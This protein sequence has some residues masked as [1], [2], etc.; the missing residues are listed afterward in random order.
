MKKIVLNG[1]WNGKGINPLTKETIEFKEASV[2]GSNLNDIINS[3]CK[4]EDIFYRDNLEKYQ[5]YENFNYVYTKKFDVKKTDG[6]I[7]LVFERLDTYCDVYLNGTHLSYCDNG[8]I[9][10]RFDV[11]DMIREQ[12]NE[13]KIYFYSPIA[14]TEGKPMLKG[15]F[16]TE[17]MYTRRMQCTYGWDWVGRFVT[18]GI[19]SDVF[20]ELYQKNEPALEGIYV[21][22]KS[23]DDFGAYIGVKINFGDNFS[24]KIYDFEIYDDEGNLVKRHSKY[25]AYHEYNFNVSIED[26]KL[27]YPSGYGSQPLYEL[28][29]MWNGNCI[30]RSKFG[31]RTVKIMQQVDAVGS[32]E[33]NKCLELKKSDFSKQYDHNTE[34]S[35]FILVVNGIRIQVRGANWVPCEPYEN[36]KTREKTLKS[37]GLAKE[38]GLNMLRVWGGGT[39]ESKEFYDECSRLGILVTQ[40][41]LM[42]CGTYPEKQEWFIRQLNKEAEYAAKLIRNQACLMWWSGDNE[43]AV[44][45]DDVMQDHPGRHAA[46]FGIQPIIAKFDP[47]RDFLPSSPY[48]GSFFASNTAGTTHNT[49]FLGNIFKIIDEEN[50][51]DYKERYKM[52]R[53]R[54]IAEES[55]FGGINTFSLK[56]FLTEEDIFG[57]DLTMIQY[58]TKGNPGLK[59]ELFEYFLTLTEKVLGSFKNGYDRNF[60]MQYIQYECVR[61]A[62]E[63]LRREAWFESGVVFWMM[64]DCWPAAAGWTFTDY[65][66]MPKASFY[67]FK[68]CSKPQICTIDNRDGKYIVSVSNNDLTDVDGEISVFSINVCTNIKRNIYIG[69]FSVDAQS[70]KDVY[71][72]EY[73]ENEI[74]VAEI[75]C[76]DVSDRAFYKTGNLH[77]VES[78]VEYEIKSDRIIL[79][80]DK[81]IQAV[82]IDGNVILRD[83]W[84][85]MLPGEEKEIF[86]EI[87][88]GDAPDISI[89]AYGF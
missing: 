46:M 37:L 86:F 48:G 4:G 51:D 59:K 9:S 25:C 42:A 15:A 88:E 83:N 71:N 81:Y 72:F 13:I 17:R 40:D 38:M 73:T 77:I 5:K 22:T 60:K 76:G 24:N 50:L 87:T 67:S 8:H 49:Q 47:E 26:A 58:H 54:F 79:K 32:S 75:I 68:R 52:L 35:G 12:E 7:I 74:I 28:K 19:T 78:S 63:Q 11:T 43:N 64:S 53:A 1:N 45:G 62:L 29:V 34:F 3:S 80:A 2:P 21:Y 41:F 82:G 16:T 10:Y 23:I 70:A 33:Y 84:F 39:F 6:K 61:I 20:I 55:T 85:S 31:I 30:G 14:K 27:W 66:L 36:G 18:C 89:N 57:E 69:K 56:K 65:Y 44:W